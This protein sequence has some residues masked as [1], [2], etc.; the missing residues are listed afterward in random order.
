MNEIKK[1]AQD[2]KK[3]L[4]IWKISEN[5]NIQT[6][7]LE[8]KSSLSQIKNTVETNFNRL[9]QVEDRISGLEDKIDMK[10]KTEEFLDKRLKSHKRN[11]KELCNSIKISSLLTMSIKEEEVQA[12]DI[13]NIFFK[14]IAENLPNLQKEMPIQ[15]QEAFRTLNRQDQNKISTQHVIAKTISTKN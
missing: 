11:M 2:V 12:K 14:I 13:Y 10:E 15:V 3:E 8:I 7:I 5:K 6:E 9:E 4:K 1:S